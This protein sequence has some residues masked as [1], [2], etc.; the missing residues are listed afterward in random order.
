MSKNF[1]SRIIFKTLAHH[2]LENLA[3]KDLNGSTRSTK[4]QVTRVLLSSD[5]LQDLQNT[6]GS[7]SSYALSMKTLKS[8]DGVC[9]ERGDKSYLRGDA[10]IGFFDSKGVY[11]V[12]KIMDILSVRRFSDDNGETIFLVNKY[13]PPPPGFSGHVWD[14]VFQHKVLCTRLV[15]LDV[16][17][18]SQTVL[19]AQI[20]GH[21]ALKK[22]TQRF[23]GALLSIQ[24][25]KVSF[26][27]RSCMI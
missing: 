6:F 18:K 21:V 27:I 25:G 10:N 12:G 5:I 2:G 26:V 3:I 23:G 15:G 8:H 1:N 13:L 24:L 19:A 9:Y 16:E 17:P 22:Q 14:T 7:L 20:V 11:Q 4:S